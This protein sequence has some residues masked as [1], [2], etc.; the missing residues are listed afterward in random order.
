[1]R[2]SLL[3]IAFLAA[4]LWSP[5]SLAQSRLQLGPLCTTDITPADQQIDACNQI[6]ALKVFSGGQ[7]A[8][9]YFWRAVGWN[10]KGNYSQVIADTTEALRLQGGQVALYNMRGSAYY[11]KGEYDIAIADFNAG[12][13]ADIGLYP[14]RP[15]VRSSTGSCRRT[16]RWDAELPAF[17]RGVNRV[18]ALREIHVAG[19]AVG[20]G[21]NCMG[22]VEFGEI[23]VVEFCTE[24][25]VKGI[26]LAAPAFLQN[27]YR[28]IWF[29]SSIEG[30]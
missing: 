10:K 28:P 30:L 2:R 15:S 5:D 6:I 3:M 7:L 26:P 8:T 1:M 13:L 22:A 27:V 11:D 21:A 25:A 19:G 23:L 17:F 14:A 9:I 12:Q 24:R 4:A 20:S 18:L 16:G 29:N